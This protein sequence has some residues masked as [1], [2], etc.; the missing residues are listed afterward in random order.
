MEVFGFCLMDSQEKLKTIRDEIDSI[1]SKICSLLVSRRNLAISAKQYKESIIDTA[2]EEE[3]IKKSMFYGSWLQVIYKEI[4][5]ECR[6][7]Q[8]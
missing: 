3:I 8:L 4:I 2:R 6:K 5:N 7:A 1:D